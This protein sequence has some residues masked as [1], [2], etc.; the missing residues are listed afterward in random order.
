M[1][2]DAS[3]SGPKHCYTDD[4]EYLLGHATLSPLLWVEGRKLPESW[5]MGTGLKLLCNEELSRLLWYW[6][7]AAFSVRSRNIS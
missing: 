1:K 3:C 4:A 2:K 6:F 7:K 5:S